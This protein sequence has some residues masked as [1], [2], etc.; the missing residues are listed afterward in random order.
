MSNEIKLTTPNAERIY[1]EIKQHCTMIEDGFKILGTN[2]SEFRER[3]SDITSN[4]VGHIVNF[5]QNKAS[6]II[7]KSPLSSIGFILFSTALIARNAGNFPVLINE[8]KA[9]S[10]APIMSNLNNRFSDA[11]KNVSKSFFR[12]VISS[13]LTGLNR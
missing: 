9:N 4:P 13:V 1:Q 3:I 8:L 5:S 11:T 12:G 10:I 7:R 2:I 6:D